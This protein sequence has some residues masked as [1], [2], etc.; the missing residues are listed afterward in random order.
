[1]AS[2]N[3]IFY[4]PQ[5]PK[6]HHSLQGENEWGSVVLNFRIR[7]CRVRPV[8]SRLKGWN[9]T[10]SEWMLSIQITCKYNLTFRA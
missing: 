6:R 10:V 1:M 7:S 4:G 5:Y 3:L 8:V 9:S 2:D